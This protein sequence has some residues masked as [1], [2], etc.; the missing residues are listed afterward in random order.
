MRRNADTG[1]HGT[2]LDEI[3]L[4]LSVISKRMSIAGEVDRACMRV[5]QTPRCCFAHTATSRICAHWNSL[6]IHGRR[7]ATCLLTHILIFRAD[8]ENFGARWDRH[9]GPV[10]IHWYPQCPHFLYV[11][12]IMF[13]QVHHQSLTSEHVVYCEADLDQHRQSALVWLS[14]IE[15]SVRCHTTPAVRSGWHWRERD[16][17]TW[18]PPSGAG[19][20]P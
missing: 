3:H 8:S 5:S 17:A 19:V 14:G 7:T 12:S 18:P 2:T 15:T 11:L 10:S 6:F 20:L 13:S 16:T 4:I 1:A 9:H